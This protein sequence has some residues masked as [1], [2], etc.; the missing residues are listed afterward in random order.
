MI[1]LVGGPPRCGKSTLAQ[2]LCDRRA[3]PWISTDP[4]VQVLGAFDARLRDVGD[5]ERFAQFARRL[6]PHLRT[7][8]LHASTC[9]EDLTVEGD[10]F[11]PE[12]CAALAAELPVVPCFLGR[13]RTS[14]AELET[15]AGHNDWLSDAPP[16]IRNRMP[17]WITR[18]SRLIAGQCA[19]L[20]LPYVD[21]AG[22]WHDGMA[23]AQNL[24]TDARPR[25]VT[26]EVMGR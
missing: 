11:L 23:R 21:L 4:V 19:D 26:E 20:G 15:R 8:I 2:W 16:E 9:M 6:W 5:E 14:V 24:L 10:S 12:Q 22:D 1:Y 13:S 3:V 7:F 17:E 18:R 25:S